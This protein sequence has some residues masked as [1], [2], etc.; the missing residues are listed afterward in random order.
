MPLEEGLVDAKGF[1]TLGAV[2]Q[3]GG[4][5]FGAFVPK[6]I[7]DKLGFR[8]INEDSPNGG[9][10]SGRLFFVGERL[11]LQSVNLARY[12][13]ASTTVGPTTIPGHSL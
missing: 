1:S 11:D 13:W 4:A 12:F 10:S 3:M 5:V 9:I 7:V 8:P 6:S 2:F